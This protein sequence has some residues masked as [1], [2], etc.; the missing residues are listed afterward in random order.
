VKKIYDT[1]NYKYV[2]FLRKKSVVAPVEISKNLE[3]DNQN[4]TDS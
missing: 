3:S 4:V 1:M 2:P